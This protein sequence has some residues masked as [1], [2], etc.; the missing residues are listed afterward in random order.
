MKITDIKLWQFEGNMP[1]QGTLWEERAGRPLDIY[2]S[3][4]SQNAKD[5]IGRQFPSAGNNSYK[6]TQTFLVVETDE[7][8]SGVVGPLT[9]DGTA[10]YIITQLKPL[11]V[12][13]NPLATELLWELMYRNTPNGRSGDNMIAISYLDYALWD[14]KGKWA[15]QPVHRL[16][17]G[18][19][20]KE[21]PAYA[22]TAGFSLEP[23]QAAKRVKIIKEEGYIGSK[24][25]FRCGV[26]D[27]IAGEKKN[28]QL[29]ESLREAAGP[30]MDIMIDAWANWGLPYSIKMAHAL[31]D[32][33]PAWI[34][35]PIQYN[36]YES[37]LQLKSKSPIPIAGGEH[38][39]TR[40]N[41]KTL[42]DRNVFDIYQFEPVWAGG[43]SE[44]IK[45]NALVTS[46]DATFI[47]HV[48]LP[49]ASAQIAFTLNTITTPMLEYH[50]ILGEIYQFFLA[51]P[52]KPK[53]GIF[54]PPE[55]SGL[56]ISID[57]NKVKKRKQI[58]YG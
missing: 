32:Y 30:N 29:M 40:W 37:Y 9:G 31:K 21:I 13:K 11:L 36:L 50:Y 58:L 3:Y 49:A 34:E 15:N 20:Q 27:G 38:E 7:S 43:V 39:F 18:P 23:E 44:L 24:W 14:I 12:H 1:Y 6:V 45:I 26:G 28:V 19:V 41:V 54:Y 46:H 8:V 42:L 51:D 33:S 5:T 53:R 4:R 2:P 35:E 56:G 10:Y 25:F 57:N 16:L 22:S 52:V 48:Y 55:K 47:P 17:G